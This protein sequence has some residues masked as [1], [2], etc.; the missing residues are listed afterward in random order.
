MT[1]TDITIDPVLYQLLERIIREAPPATEYRVNMTGTRQDG[2]AYKFDQRFAAEEK[3]QLPWSVHD[4]IIEATW[5][6]ADDFGV[7]NKEHLRV[8]IDSR[9]DGVAVGTS[10]LG[11]GQHVV[12]ISPQARTS[13][14]TAA[15]GEVIHYVKSEDEAVELMLGFI[16]W[17]NQQPSSDEWEDDYDDRSR[18]DPLDERNYPLHER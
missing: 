11:L 12:R 14:S 9:H 18:Y 15:S 10:L 17:I 5:W 6:A 4:A 7:P 3:K 8:F 2:S 13:M 1:S 16:A